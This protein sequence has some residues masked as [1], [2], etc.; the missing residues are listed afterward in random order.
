MATMNLTKQDF[1]AKVADYTSESWVMKGQRPAVIDFYAEWCGPCRRLLPLVEKFSEEYAGLIDVYK[2]NVDEEEGL[3]DD[4][5]V[6]TIPTLLF[7]PLEG[8]PWRL[9]GV[10]S[11][12]ILKDGFERLL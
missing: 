7:V 5:R 4:F 10:L 8:E 6:H 12:S 1:I 2:V 3:A 11:Q 9:Q